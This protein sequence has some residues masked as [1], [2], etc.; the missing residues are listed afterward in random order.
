MKFKI[1]SHNLRIETGW[2]EREKLQCGK[3]VKLHASQRV[4][5]ICN[6]GK[7]ED[8]QHFIMECPSYKLQR[9]TLFNMANLNIEMILMNNEEKFISIMSSNEPITIE[10][11]GKFIYRCSKMRNKLWCIQSPK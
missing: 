8:E 9:N 10:A 6:L 2:Y 1:S 4:C 11:L 3:I 7:E 5:K